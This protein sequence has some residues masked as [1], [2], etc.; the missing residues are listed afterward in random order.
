MTSSVWGLMAVA[1]ASGISV[2]TGL[3][4]LVLPVMYVTVYRV[5]RET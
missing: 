5:K 3:T 1:I 4:L 2:F